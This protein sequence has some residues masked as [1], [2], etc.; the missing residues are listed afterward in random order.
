MSAGFGSIRFCEIDLLR[1]E[2]GP[3]DSA[4]GGWGWVR[5]R[6]IGNVAEGSRGGSWRST[7]GRNWGFPYG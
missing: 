5:M 3:D 7:S 4:A 6:L 2:I 1:A